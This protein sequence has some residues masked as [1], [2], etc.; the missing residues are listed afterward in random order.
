MSDENSHPTFYSFGTD[1]RP[2]CPQCGKHMHLTGRAPKFMLGG[3]YECKTFTC[4][5][6]AFQQI[7]A[8]ATSRWMQV[9]AFPVQTCQVKPE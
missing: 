7:V 9:A 5:L 6:S 8:V 2:R 4:I 1:D 3:A